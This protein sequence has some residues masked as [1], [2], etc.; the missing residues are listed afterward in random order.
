MELQIQEKK[1]KNNN[2]DTINIFN[3]HT[4][5]TMAYIYVN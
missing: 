1:R 4:T 5:A 3:E 2:I